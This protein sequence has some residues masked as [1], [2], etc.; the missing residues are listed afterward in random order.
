MGCCLAEMGF[1]VGKC[2]SMLADNMPRE[3][4]L[5]LGDSGFELWCVDPVVPVGPSTVELEMTPLST[6]KTLRRR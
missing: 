4:L 2:R 5:R 1:D 6:E 3:A